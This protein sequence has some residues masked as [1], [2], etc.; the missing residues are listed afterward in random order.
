MGSR[1]ILAMIRFYKRFISPM[2][3]PRCRFD[4]SCSQYMYI[5]VERYG[6]LKGFWLGIKRLVRCQ[7]CCRGG[8]DPVP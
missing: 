8:Y 3:G 5:A 6:A 4:P 7:P 2:I 1:F